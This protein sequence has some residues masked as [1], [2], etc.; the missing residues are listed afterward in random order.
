MWLLPDEQDRT[1]HLADQIFVA[2]SK[3]RMFNPTFF[4]SQHIQQIDLFFPE[5]H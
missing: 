4:V 5:C 3:Y 2:P 1:G